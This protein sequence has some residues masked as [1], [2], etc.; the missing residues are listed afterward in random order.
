M[1][2]VQTCA[3]PI[4][5][6]WGYSDPPLA[7]RLWQQN[8]FG[9]DLI[10]GYRGGSLYYFTA[11]TSGAYT[12]NRAILLDQKFST[13]T[14][15]PTIQNFFMVSDIYRIVLA[16]GCDDINGSSS[17]VDGN[18]IQNPML[19][20]WSGQGTPGIWYPTATNQAGSI[21]LSRGTKIV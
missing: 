6:G 5:A 3:L 7:N 19:I 8:N 16:F 4:C 18:G 15:I 2:G 11:E 21:T 20:R 1:T 12:F 10:L 17:A 9:E 13:G 14:S